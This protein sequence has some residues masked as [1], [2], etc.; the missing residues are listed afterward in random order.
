MPDCSK[1]ERLMSMDGVSFITKFS[2]FVGLIL[3]FAVAQ[4]DETL[5]YETTSAYNKI[6]V[7]QDHTG[8]RILRFGEGGVRQSVVKPRDP[9]HL[10]LPY[11]RVAM[12]G[13]ALTSD[14]GR[15]LVVGLGG[16]T[17]PMFLRRHYPRAI[18]DVVDIDPDVV[19]V[20]KKFFE[21]REDYYVNAHVADGREFV[22]KAWQ[23]YDVIILD[24]FGAN[25][26][27]AQ[28]T[29]EEFLRAVRH[30][31]APDGVV[32]A[33]VWDRSSNLLYDSM[34]RTYQEVFEQ[35]FILAVRGASNRILLAL[36]RNRPPGREELA[37]LARHVSTIKRFTFD[38]GEAVQFGYTDVPRVTQHRQILRDRYLDRDNPGQFQIRDRIRDLY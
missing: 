18:I 28:L 6:V 27:P 38:L 24:A 31:V 4:A 11:A 35:L 16:G 19:T 3:L 37:R 30:A 20:A 17:L 25:S 9:G 5:L 15:F 26:I 29:T 7:T 13:L 22:E 32:I 23:P 14:P 12:A 34:V 1:A 10:A 21:F 36:P 33:N 8:L 2:V